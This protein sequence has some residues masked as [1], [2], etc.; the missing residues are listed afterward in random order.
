MESG[1]D[2]VICPSVAPLGVRLAFG[3]L[4]DETNTLTLGMFGAGPSLHFHINAFSDLDR[5]PWL[6]APLAQS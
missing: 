6:Q 2:A 4:R 3:V 1:Y 5:T